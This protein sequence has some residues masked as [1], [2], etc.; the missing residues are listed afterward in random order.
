MLFKTVGISLLQ[1]DWHVSDSNTC[2]FTQKSKTIVLGVKNKQFTAFLNEMIHQLRVN[3]PG[4][5]A[6]GF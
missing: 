2:K 1:H 5:K 4:V 3:I 6:K